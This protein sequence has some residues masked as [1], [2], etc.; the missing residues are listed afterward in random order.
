M[1]T[2]SIGEFM[3][4]M[5]RSNNYHIKAQWQEKLRT[6]QEALAICEETGFPEAEQRKQ[7]VL[8]EMGGIRR[9][10]G[11]YDPSH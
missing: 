8:F 5:N 10:F 4:L 6:L 2:G 9:R 7:Q 1:A 3:E 11:Q